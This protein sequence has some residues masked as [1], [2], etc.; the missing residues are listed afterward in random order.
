MN[1]TPV[2]FAQEGELE[3]VCVC[4]CLLSHSVVSKL[5]NLMDCSLPG[6]SFH[7]F[8]SQEYGSGLPVP[9]PG[10]TPTQG[11]NPRLMCLLNC[12]QILYCWATLNS[13]P[14]MFHHNFLESFSFFFCVES[15][16][17]TDVVT[18]YFPERVNREELPF[19]LTADN[20]WRVLWLRPNCPGKP[21]K[22]A[23][24]FT[25]IPWEDLPRL[26]SSWQTHL[27]QAGS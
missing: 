13:I 1:S 21:H 4:S 25:Q 23:R 3:P 2:A 11:W 12:R 9:P 18:E 17:F 27:L 10:D 8:S 7:G 15:Q 5:C 22:C 16:N 19:L 6:S 26:A 14:F 24:N 20:A